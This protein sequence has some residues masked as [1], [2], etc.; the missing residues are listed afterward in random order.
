MPPGCYVERP[1]PGGGPKRASPPGFEL[2]PSEHPRGSN[3]VAYRLHLDEPLSDGVRR[4]AAEQL[5]RAAAALDDPVLDRDVAVHRARQGVKR[6]RAL[7]RLARPALGK[8]YAEE[9]ARY[10]D[11]A[12]LLSSARDAAV[13]VQ[14]YD[15]VL[16]HFR[17]EAARRTYAPIRRALVGRRRALTNGQAAPPPQLDAFRAALDRGRLAI[18]AWSLRADGFDA[19]AGGLRRTYR[20]GRAAMAAAYRKPSEEGFHEWRKHVK[21]H[22]YHALLLRDVWAPVVRARGREAERLGE[23]LGA[24]H[25]LA[26]LALVLD[27]ERGRFGRA[28]TLPAFLDLLA[29]RRGELQALARPLGGRL[30]AERAGAFAGRFGEYWEVWHAGNGAPPAPAL[31]MSN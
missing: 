8:H 20:D 9:N 14:T 25:D 19:L 27:E 18:P 28:S 31:V 7:L 21:H 13:A 11:A 15:A 26:V 29:R 30:F 17:G 22:A 10:R 23:V 1:P 16:D 5:D 2:G 6:L 12:H 24:E 4:I 3:R